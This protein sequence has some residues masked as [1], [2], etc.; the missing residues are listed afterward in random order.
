MTERLQQVTTAFEARFGAA[1][2][3]V[4][5][6]P[7]RVNLI[8]EHT[9]Y[10][11]GFCLPMAIDRAVW[12]ALRPGRDD[13]IILH[14]LDF[15]ET[16]SFSLKRQQQGETG[17]H[18]YVEGVAW[19]LRQNGYRLS[20]WEGVVS[21]DVPIGSG[22]SSSA[23]LTLAAARAFAAVSD[24]A[25]DGVG[26]A[27]IGQQVENKW[28][29]L[30]TGIMDQLI[31][32]NAIAGHAMLLDCRSLSLT[33]VPLPPETA[34][35]ILDTNTRRGLVDSAY[36]QRRAA[37]ETAARQLGIPAL[38]DISLAEFNRQADRL[39]PII[40]QRARHVISEN[41]RTLLAAEAMRQ[42][43]AAQMGQLMNA[44]HQSLRDDFEVSSP[45][46][47]TIVELAQNHPLS[48][49]A[50]MTGAGF[51]GCAVAMVK[52][53]PAGLQDFMRRVEAGYR[54]RMQITATLFVCQ[55]T[56]GASFIQE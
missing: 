46:L 15:E 41:E 56:G 34:V 17:W 35:V 11:D 51:G 5:R 2:D 29:S 28:L 22:L 30:Q 3:I 32:A 27:Q 44:S 54:A 19:A 6:A 1:P 26:M 33:P 42:N 45:A 20:A 48:Y 39:D 52:D 7:G 9:D 50:R 43:D 21:G 49:G 25:W 53:D 4:V 55:A 47:D 18:K 36:N 40:R 16:G 31:S 23:A 10:N 24:F 12:I 38:R 13:Q 37:C 8:G 14:S